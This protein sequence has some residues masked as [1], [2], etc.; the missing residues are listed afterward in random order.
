M[1]ALD[2]ISAKKLRFFGTQMTQ[3]SVGGVAKLHKTKL[4][5]KCVRARIEG[6]RCDWRVARASFCSP[7]RIRP[8]LRAILAE[9]VKKNKA[10]FRH[11][12]RYL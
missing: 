7:S 11:L 2:K 6:V 5:E 12:G 10:V 8:P 9:K 4:K 3:H 1:R